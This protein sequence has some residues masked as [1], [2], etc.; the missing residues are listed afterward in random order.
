[1]MRQP[2]PGL[3][4]YK[5][6]ARDILDVEA[7]NLLS[8]MN[9]I[10]T[11]GEHDEIV[12]G[13][14]Q[15]VTGTNVNLRY[16]GHELRRRKIWAQ[17]GA[18][19]DGVLVYSYTG[20]TYPVANATSNW[21]DSEVLDGM[22]RKM[23]AFLSNWSPEAPQMNHLIVTAYDDGS[24]NIGWHYDKV[25]SLADDGWIAIV[26]LGPASRRFALRRR[27]KEN[28]DQEKMPVLFDEIVPAGTLILMNIATNIATQHSVP[29][30]PREDIGL[31][32][33]IVW[34]AIKTVVTQA[35]LRK[36]VSKTEKDRE[37][38]K[39]AREVA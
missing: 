5:N 10:P 32:G 19:E 12:P 22:S 38:R 3:F 25:R 36:K 24:H 28:E 7:S 27:A 9:A 20:F 34:R 2:V 6:F 35:E 37:T 13:Q 26:K 16:R 30:A 33:S 1:M 18:V 23:N 11:V 31:S 21:E 4:L 17:S 14:L 15:W 29:I 39:R 8:E